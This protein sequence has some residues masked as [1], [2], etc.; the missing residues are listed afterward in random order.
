MRK[1]DGSMRFCIDYRQLNA[2][3]IKDA[4]PLPNIDEAF[5]HLSGH[6]LFS[7][8]DLNS[9]YWQVAMDDEDKSKTAFVTRK[10][11]FQFKVM[12]F[13]LTCAPATFE[14]L[15]ETVLAGLQWDLCLVYLDDIIVIGKSFEDMLSNLMIYC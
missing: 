1:K 7:T 14:R 4:Y 2:V 8:L 5:D 9:G 15:M 11:L 13:G 10:G 3:T 12:P 6:A